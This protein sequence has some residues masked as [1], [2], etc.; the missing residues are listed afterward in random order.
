MAASN[1]SYP[2]LEVAVCNCSDGAPVCHPPLV[3]VHINPRRRWVLG[4]VDN[5]AVSNGLRLFP[6]DSESL[7]D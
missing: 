6:V 7:A 3:I 4:N 2:R 5:L 1:D